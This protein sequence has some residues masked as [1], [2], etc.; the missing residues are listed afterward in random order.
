MA[1]RWNYG[2]GTGAFCGIWLCRGDLFALRIIGYWLLHQCR[3]LVGAIRR[4]QW[5]LAYQRSLSL[6]GTMRGLV[7]GF[8]AP[9]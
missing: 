3:L 8:R 7:Y 2:Y 1:S 5:L 9:G 4:G 6:R